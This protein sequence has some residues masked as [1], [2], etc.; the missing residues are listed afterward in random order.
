MDPVTIGAGISAISSLAGGIMGS[1]SAQGLNAANRAWQT[2]MSNTQYQR[3]VEDMRKAGLNPLMM[4]GKGGMTS[5]VPSVAA[6]GI[7]GAMAGAGLANAGKALSDIPMQKAQ[8]TLVDHQTSTTDSQ[9]ALNNASTDLQSQKFF[10]E[11]A[12]ADWIDVQRLNAQLMLPYQ[13]RELLSRQ[14]LN[15]SNARNLDAENPGIS[16]KSYLEDLTGR[17]AGSGMGILGWAGRTAA[18]GAQAASDFGSDTFNKFISNYQQG[19]YGRQN[20]AKSTNP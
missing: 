10:T 2:Q 16:A 19:L 7:P 12:T 8:R 18:D 11:K 13:Q 17:A 1:S 14:R 20:S 5:T 9:T 3:G 6:Q 4:Y 15:E